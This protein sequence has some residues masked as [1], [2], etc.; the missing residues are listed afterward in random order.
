[1][2][3]TTIFEPEN[4]VWYMKDNEPLEET[5][6]SVHVR[7]YGNPLSVIKTNES[8]MFKGKTD[9]VSFQW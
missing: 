1:M 8:V 9:H 6:S 2:K 4:I 7:I 5:I 3:I